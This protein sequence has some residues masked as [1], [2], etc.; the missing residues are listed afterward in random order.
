MGFAPMRGAVSLTKHVTA[1]HVG[2]A[3]LTGNSGKGL[4][5]VTDAP[6]AAGDESSSHRFEPAAHGVDG[7]TPNPLPPQ[8]QLIALTREAY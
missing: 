4:G 1:S 2:I 6:C 3:Y 5:V 8:P 7:T